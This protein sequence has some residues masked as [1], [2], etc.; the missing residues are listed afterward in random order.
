MPRL[1]WT[2]ILQFYASHCLWDDGL[3]YHTQLF[4]LKMGSF[5]LFCLGWSGTSILPVSA[6]NRACHCTQLLV[7]MGSC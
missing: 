3:V 1:P 7:K 2:T 5:Q 6:S 4:S